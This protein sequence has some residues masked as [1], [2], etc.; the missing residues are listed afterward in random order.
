MET[1]DFISSVNLESKKE[2]GNLVSFNGQNLTFIRLSIKEVYFL[3]NK[4]R[5][6]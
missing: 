5:R 4:W 3:F 2:N 6:H 1:E